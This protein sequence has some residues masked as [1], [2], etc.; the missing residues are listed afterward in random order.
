MKRPMLIVDARS[1]TS[2]V[3]NR[4]RGGGYECEQYYEKSNIDFMNLANIHH[5]RR[6]FQQMRALCASG[7]E[8]AARYWRRSFFFLSTL[9][10][11]T[12]SF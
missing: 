11:Y 10:E 5:V 3:T 7:E 12:F 8:Q 4:A 9:K 6:S 2:A 1:Y